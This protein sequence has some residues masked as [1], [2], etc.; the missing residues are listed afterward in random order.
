MSS[1]RVITCDGCGTVQERPAG[2][3]PLGWR[4]VRVW[5]RTQYRTDASSLYAV[6][7]CSIGCILEAMRITELVAPG[8]TETDRA[9]ALRLVQ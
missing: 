9:R 8:T 3:F 1:P 4:R 6:D 2:I 5:G 7:V